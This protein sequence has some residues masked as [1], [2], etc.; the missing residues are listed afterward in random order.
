[1]GIP[2]HT[3]GDNQWEFQP[4]FFNPNLND[5]KLSKK[6][7]Y[8]IPEDFGFKPDVF[9]LNLKLTNLCRKGDLETRVNILTKVFGPQI[10]NW[11][12]VKR[13]QNFVKNYQRRYP[14][15]FLRSQHNRPPLKV[16]TGRNYPTFSRTRLKEAKTI[17]KFFSRESF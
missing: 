12:G 17:E 16:G 2:P 3:W 9:L 11:L 15:R 5:K 10:S 7:G 8:L 1:M 14:Q 6:R 13:L 4:L